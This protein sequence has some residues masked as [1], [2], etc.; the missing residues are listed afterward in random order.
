MAWAWTNCPAGPGGSFG[1]WTNNPHFGRASLPPP[2]TSHE[3]QS[4]ISLQKRGYVNV[5]TVQPHVKH[6]GAHAHVDQPFQLTEYFFL[7]KIA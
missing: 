3:L 1:A 6:A 5:Q 7:I 4:S 2:L